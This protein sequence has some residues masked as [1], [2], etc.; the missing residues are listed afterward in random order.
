MDC[1]NNIKNNIHLR[2]SLIEMKTMMSKGLSVPKDQE[3]IFKL[4]E[5]LKHEDPKVRKNTA[6]II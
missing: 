5:L 4:K 1:I 2:E 6:I 3:L